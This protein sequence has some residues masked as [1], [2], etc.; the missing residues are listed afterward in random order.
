MA[1]RTRIIQQK[2]QQS[3]NE[4]RSISEMGRLS[5]AI[6]SLVSATKQNQND[7]KDLGKSF[8]D[9]AK[10]GNGGG[11]KGKSSN[12]PEGLSDEQVKK[13]GKIQSGVGMV[14]DKV[15][16][17]SISQGFSEPL[18]KLQKGLTDKFSGIKQG[19]GEELG[20]GAEAL[21]GAAGAAEGIGGGLMGMAGGALAAAGPIAGVAMGL[22]AIFDFW[23]SG[24][25]AKLDAQ[26]KMMGGTIEGGPG[27]ALEDMKQS[28]KGTEQYRKLM[29]HYNYEVPVEL[30]NQAKRDSLD[31]EKQTEMDALGYKQSLLKDEVNYEIGLRKDALQFQFNQENKNL[32]ARQSREKALYTLGLEFVGK[33]QTIAERALQAINS[34]TKQL[35][36]GIATIQ[37]MFSSTMQD[38]TKISENAQELAFRFGAAADD[39]LQISNLFRLMNKTTGLVGENLVNGMAALAKSNGVSPQAVF[40]QISKSAGELYKFSDGTADNFAKQA[41]SLTKMGVSMESMM[42]ASDTMVLNYK[43]SIKAEMNL[44][45]MLGKNVD[46]SEARARLMSGDQAGGADAIRTAL[47]GTDIGSMNAFQKQSLSQ[48]TGMDIQSL[49]GLMQGGQGGANGALTANEVAGQNIAKGALKQEISQ[50]GEK[51]G[52]EQAQRKKMLEFEQKER[53][54][55]LQ[56]EQQQRLQNL[57]VEQKYRVKYS[58]LQKEQDIDKMAASM[59]AEAASGYL[60]NLVGGSAADRENNKVYTSNTNLSKQ[61]SDM[62]S[63]QA[64]MLQTLINSGAVSGNDARLGKVYASMMDANDSGNLKQV[65]DIV[66]KTFGPE[67]E[68]YN[69]AVQQQIA[70]NKEVYGVISEIQNYQIKRKAGTATGDETNAYA[71]RLKQLQTKY[72]EDIAN[73]LRAG[74]NGD[75]DAK[76]WDTAKGAAYLQQL[77]S[78]TTSTANATLKT[79]DIQV[80]ATTKSAETQNKIQVQQMRTLS[81]SEYQTSVYLEMVA[82]LGIASQFLGQISENTAKDS[83]ININGKVLNAALL[84]QAKKEYGIAR[85]VAIQ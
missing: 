6:E 60:T 34:S 14:F 61:M 38:S 47:A 49:M 79:N 15:L 63:S 70:H 42:K 81:E 23:D 9:Y 28:L 72:P 31:Y 41:I 43:D 26:F 20:A 77:N 10:S 75:A 68:N 3:R 18:K 59:Q 50:A 58:N 84:T 83:T 37:P 25:L 19:A 5:S 56:V 65:T 44:S 11:S 17:K 52:L 73:F 80:K 82:L 30:A 24:G 22:K 1:K 29:A 69:K 39:V 67:L 33:Y 66:S 21:E 64:S 71:A 51:L 45:A 32:E 48:A 7:L 2:I 40:K 35:L 74:F 55:M 78:T 16:P 54:I 85:T 8:R 4:E 12:T 76:N 27:A 57:A 13:Y 46:L 36:D 53:L 62:M